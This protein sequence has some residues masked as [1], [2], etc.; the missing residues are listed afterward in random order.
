M[1]DEDAHGHVDESMD[2]VVDVAAEAEHHGLGKLAGANPVDSA[3]LA[4][5]EHVRN[6]REQR[7]DILGVLDQLGGTVLN[8][9]VQSRQHVLE[10]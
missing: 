2:T 8:E 7:L 4:V 5:G 6:H 9:V 1:A 10:V 3:D